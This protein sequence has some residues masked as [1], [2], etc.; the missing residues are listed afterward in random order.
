MDKPFINWCRVSQPSTVV[1][2]SYIL[3]M[4][5][6][7]Y[8]P[9]LYY[10]VWYLLTNG[11]LEP[12]ATAKP[13]SD[14]SLIAMFLIIYGNV[15]IEHNCACF[16][17][18]GGDVWNEFHPCQYRLWSHSDGLLLGLQRANIVNQEWQHQYYIYI[19]AYKHNFMHTHTY[20]Y[21]YV[22][23]SDTLG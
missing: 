14:G 3:Y 4:R 22:S 11:E 12:Y 9:S 10:L 2:I 17:L 5:V 15:I 8:V 19:Y 16:F 6:W 20:I 18:G 7:Y 23:N 13:L 1:I 21:V